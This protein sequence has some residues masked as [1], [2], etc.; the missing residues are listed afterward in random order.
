MFIKETGWG[1]VYFY[2]DDRSVSTSP[3]LLHGVEALTFSVGGI[4]EPCD[5]RSG[6]LLLHHSLTLTNTHT[7]SRTPAC[8]CKNV[9]IQCI[10]RTSNKKKKEKCRKV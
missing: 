8:K 9:L 6:P 10:I 5:L 4:I 1:A 3:P 7:E 2:L